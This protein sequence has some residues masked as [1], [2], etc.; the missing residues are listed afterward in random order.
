MSAAAGV[1]GGADPEVMAAIERGN[2]VV[3]LDVALGEGANAAQLGR[4]KL[5]LFV[6]DVSIWMFCE[7]CCICVCIM[8]SVLTSFSIA[9]SFYYCFS[10]LAL[11]KTF[12]NC[13]QENS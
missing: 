3:F 8:I 1:M 13:V 11:A 7:K 9:H 12:D 2:A 5:E 6:K 10:A 4:I